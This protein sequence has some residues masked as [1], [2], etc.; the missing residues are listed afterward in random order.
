MRKF[1]YA[2]FVMLV[3]AGMIA[4]CKKVENQSA[5]NTSPQAHQQIPAAPLQSPMGQGPR[6]CLRSLRC[7]LTVAMQP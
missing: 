6:R 7:L 2:V 1:V 4:G 3:I 5:Q